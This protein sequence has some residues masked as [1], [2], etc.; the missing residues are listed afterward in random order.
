MWNDIIELHVLGNLSPYHS[1][2]V[3]V[4]FTNMIVSM[5]LQESRKHP[6]E[7]QSTEGEIEQLSVVAIVGSTFSYEGLCEM[8][9][10]SLQ[11]M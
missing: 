8:D 1:L 3:N 6:L 4:A 10:H 2:H 5:R 9:Y 7:N 11:Y